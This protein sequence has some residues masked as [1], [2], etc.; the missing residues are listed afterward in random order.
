[1]EFLYK[2]FLDEDNEEGEESEAG[3]FDPG[4]II[5][6][7]AFCLAFVTVGLI[8]YGCKTICDFINN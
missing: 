4:K 2:R 7:M 3:G 6:G 5:H 8:F 1:M